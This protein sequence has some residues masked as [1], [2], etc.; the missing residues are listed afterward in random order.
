MTTVTAGLL[1]IL[2]A[3]VAQLVFPGSAFRTRT[4]QP[5]R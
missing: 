2:L 1:F 5:P 3:L 4:P